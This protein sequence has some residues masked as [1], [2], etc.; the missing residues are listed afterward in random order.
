[1]LQGYAPNDRIWD[2]VAP[3]VNVGKQ[4]DFYLVHSRADAIRR[5]TSIRAPGVPARLVTRAIGSDT[6]FALNY[7]LRMSQTVEDRANADPMYRQELLNGDAQHLVNILDLDIDYRVANLVT[8]VANVGSGAGVASAWNTDNADPIGD[9]HTAIEVVQDSTGKRP[10]RMTM[11]GQAWRS[12][13]RHQDIRNIIFGTNNGG[14]YPSTQQVANLFDLERIDVG[15]TYENTANEAQAES[16]S[17]IWAD[18]VVVHHQG[19]NISRQ[20][21]SAFKSFRWAAPGLANMQVERHPFD[22]K[23]KSADIEV[24]YYQVEKV[25]GPEYA[26]VI[27]AVNSST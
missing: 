7:A 8:T 18:H 1:M 5:E 11:G 15:D 27:R 6:Y 26:Y 20:A 22:T 21:P 16:I 12:L 14:G 19:P 3:V 9:I 13:R 23:T 4:S 10:N 17:P 2:Q 25:T 24:G